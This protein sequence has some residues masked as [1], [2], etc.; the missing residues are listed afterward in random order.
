[1]TVGTGLIMIDNKPKPIK[2]LSFGK[3]NV[4]V[5]FRYDDTKNP[6][7]GDWFREIVDIID[8]QDNVEE[9]T[10]CKLES[11]NVELDTWQEVDRK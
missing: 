4:T 8:E 10:I 9:V 7:V 11:Y 3:A 1:M 5:W 2:K 6:H